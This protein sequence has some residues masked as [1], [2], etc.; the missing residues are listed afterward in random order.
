MYKCVLAWTDL[1]DVAM[2]PYHLG[3]KLCTIIILIEW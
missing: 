1:A 2:H 3:G